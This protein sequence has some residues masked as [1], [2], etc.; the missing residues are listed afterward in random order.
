MEM[1]AV[2]RHQLTLLVEHVP[3]TGIWK[4]TKIRAEVSSDHVLR[5]NGDRL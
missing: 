5:W 4:Y 2:V 1:K 3:L